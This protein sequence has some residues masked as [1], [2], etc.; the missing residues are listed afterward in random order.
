MVLPPP[1]SKR[2]K[3]LEIPFMVPNAIGYF[4]QMRNEVP[5]LHKGGDPGAFLDHLD[6]FEDSWNSSLADVGLGDCRIEA[7][8]GSLQSKKSVHDFIRGD[9]QGRIYA[10]QI[11][12]AAELAKAVHDHPGQSGI[13]L[14]STMSGK[15][16]TANSCYWIAPI[17]YSLTGK[18][19]MTVTLLPNKIGLESQ[20]KNENER[21]RDFYGDCNLYYRGQL[22][23]SLL[24]YYH[25]INGIRGMDRL[26]NIADE[27]SGKRSTSPIV[28]RTK[29]MIERIKQISRLATEMDISVIFLTDEPDWGCGADGVAWQMF[30]E[31]VM[32]EQGN[33]HCFIGFSGTPYEFMNISNIWEVRQRL[34]DVYCGFNFMNGSAID[35]T[36]SIPMP[37]LQSLYRFEQQTGIR[38]FRNIHSCCYDNEERFVQ[39]RDKI[40]RRLAKKGIPYDDMREFPY[41]HEQ[42]RHEVEKSLAQAIN[43]CLIKPNLRNG[44]GLLLRMINDNGRTENLI[45]KLKPLVHSS[46]EF[47]PYMADRTHEEVEKMIKHRQ[48]AAENKPYVVCPTGAARMADRFPVSL[49]YGIE[50][51]E[52]GHVSL[53]ALLQGTVGRLT[54]NNKGNPTPLIVL[55]HKS[56]ETMN[57]FISTKGRPYKAPTSRTVMIREKGRRRTTQRKNAVL[58]KYHLTTPGLRAAW[59][60]AHEWVN[61]RM[62]GRRTLCGGNA[63]FFTQWFTEDILKE[64][65]KSV[66]S[67]QHEDVYVEPI[68]LLRMGE[69]DKDGNRYRKGDGGGFVG[70]RTAGGP[71]ST[72]SNIRSDRL[73]RENGDNREND[74]EEDDLGDIQIHICQ[75]GKRWEIV[76][77]KLRLKEYCT[78]VPSPKP[79][80][81]NK[82]GFTDNLLTPEEREQRDNCF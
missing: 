23:G 54:G 62:I 30:E 44:Q 56:Q 27:T 22:G 15:T 28:R 40:N 73:I 7:S 66:M 77:I 21:F 11:R 4:N 24:H 13:C 26:Y 1:K 49:K 34:A 72:N 25:E 37:I 61:W 52:N 74:D 60:K 55:A 9:T 18:K 59:A 51:A 8:P 76:G 31:A 75:V 6:D 39:E 2:T 12:T 10:N 78:V 46:I 57:Y 58:F 41:Y 19:Y 17:M 82:K 65:E 45:A 42:Y 14:G 70:L 3:K 38:N 32:D 64:M 67:S 80:L 36:V 29:N 68:Q 81:P 43:W 35:P 71:A 79:F 16:G 47:L 33:G 20:T 5:T 50:L 53:R 63:P 48:G 69:K